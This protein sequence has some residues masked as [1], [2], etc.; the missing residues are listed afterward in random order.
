MLGDAPREEEEDENLLSDAEMGESDDPYYWWARTQPKLRAN[1]MDIEQTHEY[2]VNLAQE[3]ENLRAARAALPEVSATSG[4]NN[5]AQPA[6]KAA[7]QLKAQENECDKASYK[8]I[9]SMLA[10]QNEQLVK[11]NAQK[12]ATI[13]TM[14]AN[15]TAMGV[16]KL[17][18]QAMATPAIFEG[19]KTGANGKQSVRDWLDCVQRF[20]T[21][22]SF[23]TSETVD[24]AV[25]FLRGEALRGGTQKQ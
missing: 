19:N 16:K 10:D 15:Q 6:D 14:A 2:L 11:D 22:A 23:N 1:A 12:D 7:E 9:A 3:R 24:F 18:L 13:A 25:A 8:L 4:D 17:L 20:S 21:S 5:E